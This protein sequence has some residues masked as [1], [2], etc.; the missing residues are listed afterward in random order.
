[1]TRRIAMISEHASP[2]G[3]L[4]G[5]DGGGQN[6]YVAQLA[7]HLAHD[8]WQVDVFTRRSSDAAPIVQGW[9]E[10]VRIVNV[11]AGPPAFVPKEEMLPFMPGFA[12][13]MQEHW[14]EL[15]PYDAVH[16]NFWMSG[17]VAAELKQALGAPFVVTFHAL[18][19]VRRLH[20]SESDGF[21]DERLEIEDRVI[22]E[23]DAIIAE[24]PQDF[25]DLQTF[26]RADPARI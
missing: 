11:P 12:A 10:G 21:P 14:A 22:A 19:R 3:T 9:R 5:V 2:V 23:A 25:E 1:M 16:A 6:V 15:G 20:Q 26:Y 7:T 17:L 13:W 4:G 18:G 24:C 8:G